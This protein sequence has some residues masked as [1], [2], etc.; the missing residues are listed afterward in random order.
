MFSITGSSFER[1]VLRKF[2]ALP[3]ITI[4]CFL[5]AFVYPGSYNW[6]YEDSIP[7][8]R[9]VSG[10]DSFFTGVKPERFHILHKGEI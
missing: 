10:F 9:G 3:V 6:S 4:N 2:L 7:C 8:S 5:R 1:K